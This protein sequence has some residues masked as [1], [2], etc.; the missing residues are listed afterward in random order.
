MAVPTLIYCS[1]GDIQFA[2]IAIKHGWL[3]GAQ[4]PGTIYF[5]PYFVDN[6]FKK[7]N[8]KRYMQALAEHR[9]YMASVVD[10]MDGH[11]WDEV[12]SWGEEA[13]QYVEVVMI[14]PKMQHTVHLVPDMIGGKPVRVGYSVAT[15]YGG[16]ELMLS[17]FIG[18]P[19]HL[20]GG[21]PG[22]QMKLTHY[23]DVVSADG[24]MARKMAVKDGLWWLPGKRPFAN[25]W[26]SFREMGEVVEDDIPR[27]A[28]ERSCINMMAAWLRN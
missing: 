19:V 4:Q 14:I 21:N 22:L 12:L 24:N 8:R 5:K 18:R 11:D 9:P 23:L 26:V 25:R 7:P 16:T 3:Y 2:E 28:F 1:K 20:L 27:K 15:E 13:A 17:E 10:W 6:N